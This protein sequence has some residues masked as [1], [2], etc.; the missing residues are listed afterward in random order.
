MPI[1]S[2]IVAPIFV[3]IFLSSCSSIFSGSKPVPVAQDD[4]KRVRNA[5][6]YLSPI[7]S[8]TSILSNEKI[9][10]FVV[11]F[12]GT[13]NNRDK[14]NRSTERET[15]TAMLAHR[16]EIG[17]Y[18]V[19]Y[20]SG[21][22]TTSKIDSALCM[23]CIPKAE[24]AL[25]RL[26]NKVADSW[27][28][29]ANIEIRV[30]VIGFSR[31]AAIGR[32]FMNLVSKTWPPNAQLNNAGAQSQVVRTV[33]L[34][35]DTVATGK[36]RS[37]QLGIAPTTDHIVHLLARDERRGLFQVV[38]DYDQDFFIVPAGE[39]RHSDRLT[40][41]TLPGVHSDV[42]GSYLDGLGSAYRVLAE[43]ILVELNLLEKDEWVVDGGVFDRGAHDSRGLID[44]AL[45][46][47]SVLEAPEKKRG[48]VIA[49]SSPL[50]DEERDHLKI[51]LTSLRAAKW[52]NFQGSA[53]S[54]DWGSA[55]APAKFLIV[56]HGE[57]LYIQRAS[58]WILPETLMFDVSTGRRTLAF[59]GLDIN[60][61]IAMSKIDI[62]DRIWSA[63]PDDLESSFEIV[64]LKSNDKTLVHFLVNHQEVE[65]FDGNQN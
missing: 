63:I 56:K 37:L 57:E 54:V 22:G 44:K 38:V 43:Q 11:A 62:T 36:E 40:E 21:P 64:F 16:L 31:G 27:A 18:D 52:N 10:I 6:L 34:L 42:G 12:D 45:L 7:P 5:S 29:N 19:D 23:S 39:L 65:R 49:K 8:M 9:K 41:I 60:G 1:I 26:R 46:V 48:K 47:K 2:R 15:I 3:T 17:G 32:H 58:I 4:R 35:F 51:R 14:L 61:K 55:H 20:L 24:E 13:E 50:T 59:G 33:G 53:M 28:A 30:L 25:E